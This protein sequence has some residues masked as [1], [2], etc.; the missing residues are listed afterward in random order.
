[1]TADQEAFVA[2]IAGHAGVSA[3]RAARA[4]RAVLCSIS[5]SVSPSIR[6]LIASEL[7]PALAACLF[8]PDHLAIPLDE[9]LREPGITATQ[10]RA[11]IARISQALVDL[12]SPATIL[13]IRGRAPT[14]LA[15][16]LGAP[17]DASAC[18][19][20]SGASSAASAG[21]PSAGRTAPAG[22]TD[23]RHVASGARPA[24]CRDARTDSQPG[25]SP[26]STLHRR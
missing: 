1:M 25:T 18:A 5:S 14:L 3:D 17:T 9:H 23:R 19:T 15:A 20:S 16:I 22:R 4:T 26:T 21:A 6:W 12:L 24:R 2:H 11:L 8:L 7:P 10:S 13:A